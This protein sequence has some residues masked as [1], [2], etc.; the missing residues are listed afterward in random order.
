M[1]SHRYMDNRRLHQFCMY[2]YIHTIKPLLCVQIYVIYISVNPSFWSVCKFL[3]Y[4]IFN[5]PRR[6]NENQK[7]NKG[8]CIDLD[9]IGSHLTI[10]LSQG[11]WLAALNMFFWSGLKNYWRSE[12]CSWSESMLKLIYGMCMQLRLYYRRRFVGAHIWGNNSKTPVVI[13]ILYFN[14]NVHQCSHIHTLHEGNISMVMGER[15]NARL[16]FIT[17]CYT[18]SSRQT[19]ACRT[20]ANQNGTSLQICTSWDR[21]IYHTFHVTRQHVYLFYFLHGYNIF[22]T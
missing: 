5:S 9:T 13:F 11:L 14:D 4:R 16:A 17:H 3:S 20:W 19:M 7:P 2:I 8:C 22:G 6:W 1:L 18:C 10:M 21:T 12:Y 15:A